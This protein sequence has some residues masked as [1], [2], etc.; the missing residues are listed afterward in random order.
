MKDNEP[1]DSTLTIANDEVTC[2]T[3]EI[4]RNGEAINWRYWASRLNILPSQAA[5]LAHCIDPIKWPSNEFAQGPLP[6]D[7]RKNIQRLE[8]WLTDRLESMPLIELVRNLGPE[9]SPFCMKQVCPNAISPSSKNE[10]RYGWKT[11]AQ[12]IADK[13]RKEHPSL[14]KD[15]ICEK[16][17]EEML[18]RHNSG[19]PRMT[20]RGGKVPQASTIASKE[21][22]KW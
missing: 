2:L 3:G 6:E 4:V 15:Q 10:D 16:T 20:G 22:I 21:G 5:K 14:S 18:S 13:L 19:E 17:R 9:S 11:S 12:V 7:L 8:E 1:I